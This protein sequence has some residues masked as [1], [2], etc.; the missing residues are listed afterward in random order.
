MSDR[1]T[2]Y[3]EDLGYTYGYYTELNPQRVYLAFLHAGLVPP[4]IGNACELGFGQGMSANLHAAASVIRWTGTD[5]NPAQASFAQELARVAGAG[6][7]LM[8]E[9]FAEFCQRSDLPEFDYIGMHGV[10][11][12]ISDENRTLLVDFIRRKLKVGGVLYISYN[13][14][15]GWASMVPMRDL[16]A[17][18]VEA[19][20]G[21]GA[22]LLGRI[23]GALE[24]VDKLMAANPLYA[25]AN[26]QTAAWLTQVKEQNRHYVAHEYFNHDWQPVA[27]SKMAEWLK[28]AKVQWACSANYLDAVDAVHLNTDQQALLAGIADP[29][30]RQTTRDFCV[31]QH[32]RR[33][34]WVKGARTLTELEQVERL[35]TQR[36]I[37]MKPRKDVSLKVLG[38]AGEATLQEAVYNP[39]LDCVADHKFKTLGQLETT[40][41]AQG[42]K[43]PQ[44]VKATMLLAATGT[45]QAAQ[46]EAITAKVK[47]HTDRINAYLMSK[48]RSS[49]DLQ[50][51]ASP[52]T[53]GGVEV[54]RFEQLFLRARQQ[55]H[56][57]EKDCAQFV[58]SLL[59]LQGH[60]LVKDGATLASAEDNMAE[61]TRQATVFF[62]KR[63]PILQ[64]LQIAA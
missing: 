19:A 22:G 29:V 5:F 31:N 58:W 15:P 12:W 27:F 14:Q 20:G 8:D 16:L 2:G 42:I 7:V 9:A 30:L 51:L 55:G 4:A 46:D 23:E 11:S 37:L 28:P 56:K 41:E 24:F 18:H 13:T 35:R 43:F 44:I 50:F 59:E 52:V 47:P 10:W 53:G 62:E 1:S 21:G 48:V 25:K 26:P 17:Q 54:G 38:S 45:L 39:I 36:F 3:I 61:L 49:G 33:D 6:A 40:L 32:F 57:T 34:Y 60:R 63:L 64:A